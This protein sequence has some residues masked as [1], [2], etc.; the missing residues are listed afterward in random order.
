MKIKTMYFLTIFFI[1]LGF[2]LMGAAL[3]PRCNDLFTIYWMLGAVFIGLSIAVAAHFIG[4]AQNK[5]K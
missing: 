4:V 1:W 3:Y 2:S 5:K